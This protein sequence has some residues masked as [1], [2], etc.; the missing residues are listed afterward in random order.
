MKKKKLPAAM[1]ALLTNTPEKEVRNDTGV[2]R[3]VDAVLVCAVCQ[4]VCLCVREC[5][6]L[7]FKKIAWISQEGGK[8]WKKCKD[9]KRGKLIRQRI[10]ASLF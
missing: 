6:Y 2:L 10:P 9:N 7:C 3:S 1:A 8:T 5:V 4:Y